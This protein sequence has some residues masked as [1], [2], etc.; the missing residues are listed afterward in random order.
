[1]KMYGTGRGR[2]KILYIYH[3]ASRFRDINLGVLIFGHAHKMHTKALA[4]NFEKKVIRY[5]IN[6]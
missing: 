6:V 4:F 3:Q 5:I 2:N 1:M